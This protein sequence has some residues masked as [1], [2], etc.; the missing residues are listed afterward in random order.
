MIGYAP[1]AFGSEQFDGTR[2]AVEAVG[3][4]AEAAAEDAAGGDGQLDRELQ[5]V[6]VEQ[7]L[8][9]VDRVPVIAVEPA[10]LG[11]GIN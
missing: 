2:R 3:G 8:V 10:A 5:Q 7:Q 1:I 9:A 11:P 6:G 4:G